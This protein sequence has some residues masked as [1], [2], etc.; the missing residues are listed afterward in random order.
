M[1]YFH[2]FMNIKYLD[3]NTIFPKWRVS[4][5]IALLLTKSDKHGIQCPSPSYTPK[6]Q[7]LINS[8]NKIRD[9]QLLFKILTWTAGWFRSQGPPRDRQQ[10]TGVVPL[11]K[12]EH[13]LPQS[14]F[15]WRGIVIVVAGGL[16]NYYQFTEKI[17][18]SIT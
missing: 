17:N 18:M 12:S 14:E 1:K 10:N 8:E 6:L 16:R 3:I 5:I 7:G 9:V 13:F 4:T 15:C 11:H 2:R